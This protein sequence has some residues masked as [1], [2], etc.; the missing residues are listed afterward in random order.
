MMRMFLTGAFGG[1]QGYNGRSLREA[2][3]TLV[4]EQGLGEVHFNAVAN[5]LK[6]TL[7]QLGVPAEL[8]NEVMALAAAT[9]DDVL[10]L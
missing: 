8:A 1:P 2:H 6:A 4:E 3:K 5:H 7:D 9:H 10:N